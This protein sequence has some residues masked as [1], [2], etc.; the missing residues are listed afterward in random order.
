MHAL[1]R[2]HQGS[3]PSW[4]T[5]VLACRGS[6]Y[7]LGGCEAHDETCAPAAAP[8]DF[9]MC[10]YHDADVECPDAYPDR[11]LVYAGYDDQRDCTA[12]ACGAP[13]GGACSGT[14]SVFKDG[15]CTMLV[16]ALGSIPLSSTGLTWV[17]AGVPLGGKTVSALSYTAGTCTPS[18]G[19]PLGSVRPVSPSTFCC[20]MS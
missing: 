18:G 5:E 4:A 17:P 13:A 9:L 12:C 16:P 11:H 15:A 2:H 19:D 7:P 6:T 14:L 8:P 1:D 3:Q 10:I 20:L